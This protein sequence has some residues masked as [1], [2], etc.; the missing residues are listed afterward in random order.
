MKHPQKIINQ[1]VANKPSTEVEK[2]FQNSMDLVNVKTKRVRKKL[3]PSTPP[4][5]VKPKNIKPKIIYVLPGPDLKHVIFCLFFFIL[6]ISIRN[7]QILKLVTRFFLQ[8][9][10]DGIVSSISNTCFDNQTKVDDHNYLSKN[11]VAT[12]VDDSKSNSNVIYIIDEKLSTNNYISEST[13]SNNFDRS[14]GENLNE[15]SIMDIGAVQTIDQDVH[16]II[17]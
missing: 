14:N 9:S 17:F 5:E 7:I 4:N 13:V 6:F 11:S 15:I 12:V 8:N 1:P 2:I 3:K 10:N 16:T